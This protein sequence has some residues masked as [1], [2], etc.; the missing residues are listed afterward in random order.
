MKIIW[1][2]FA[3]K[4]LFDIFTYYK[5]RAGKSVALKIKNNVFLATKQLLNHP[6]SGQLEPSLLQLNENH[7]YIVSGHFKIIYKLVKEEILITDIFD[8]RQDPIK[9][10]NPKRKLD[11]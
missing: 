8:T 6:D 7:R 9:I 4:T 5:I 11:K 1:S 10:N 2:D 3:S